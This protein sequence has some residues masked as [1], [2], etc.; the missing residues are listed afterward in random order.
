MNMSI[1]S[2]LFMNAVNATFF[3]KRTEYKVHLLA[4]H[5]NSESNRN[6]HLHECDHCHQAFLNKSSLENHMK[7]HSEKRPFECD[8]CNKRLKY[9]KHLKSHHKFNCGKKRIYPK[10]EHSIRHQCSQCEKSFVSSSDHKMH[11]NMHDDTNLHYCTDCDKY[12]LKQR[13]LLLHF[14]NDQRRFFKD[15]G[16]VMDGNVNKMNYKCDKF[17]KVFLDK[18]N[19][20]MHEMIHLGWNSFHCG[21]C[22]HYFSK[23]KY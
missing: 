23:Q 14:E 19:F 17:D 18:C 8:G 22:D 11:Q 5:P 2:I 20:K 12:F 6:A 13:T 15:Q 21:Q 9:K 1:H 4:K 7:Y 3:L 16:M 10:P